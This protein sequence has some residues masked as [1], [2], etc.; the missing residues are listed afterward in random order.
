MGSEQLVPEKIS[1]DVPV[2]SQMGDIVLAE[3]KSPKAPGQKQRMPDETSKP[4][5]VEI[6]SPPA[7]IRQEDVTPPE[8][9]VPGE[10]PMREVETPPPPDMSDL[11][12]DELME[13]AKDAYSRDLFDEAHSLFKMVLEK[14]PENSKAK[15]MIKRLGSKMG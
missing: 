6:P 7:S 14:D 8:K 4:E 11:S 9:V 2:T 10:P 3:A 5:K 1:P 15:F 12:P 13:R